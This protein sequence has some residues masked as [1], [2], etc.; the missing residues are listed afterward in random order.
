[1]RDLGARQ[2]VCVRARFCVRMPGFVRETMFA[3]LQCI[4]GETLA[5]RHGQLSESMQCN[6]IVHVIAAICH[7]NYTAIRRHVRL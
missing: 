3:I 5:K 4:S 2:C 6:R 1:M 7:G